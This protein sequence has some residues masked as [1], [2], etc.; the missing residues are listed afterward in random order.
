[1][2]RTLKYE[3]ALPPA[4]T[5]RGQQ[6]RFDRWRKQFNCERPHE[7]IG[8]VTPSC[9]YVPSA[10]LFPE[11]FDRD[12]LPFDVERAVVNKLGYIRWQGRRVFIGRGLRYQLVELRPAQRRRWLVCFGPLVLGFYDERDRRPRIRQISTRK[13]HTPNGG[14]DA[15]SALPVDSRRRLPTGK[16][17]PPDSRLAG[18]FLVG[19]ETEK[20]RI[21]V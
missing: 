21:Q 11:K 9:L 19:S 15:H 17:P 3:T 2:H 18:E 14:G 13:R 12:A 16:P 6:G 1:M 10:K 4:K 8:M 5:P 20:N 7:G